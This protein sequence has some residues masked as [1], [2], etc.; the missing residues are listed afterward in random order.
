MAKDPNIPAWTGRVG[1]V[2]GVCVTFGFQNR[3]RVPACAIS[4]FAPSHRRGIFPSQPPRLSPHELLY[5]PCSF[6]PVPIHHFSL[7]RRPSFFHWIFFSPFSQLPERIPYGPAT[8]AWFYIQ[9]VGKIVWATGPVPH[10]CILLICYPHRIF[11]PRTSEWMRPISGTGCAI[12]IPSRT[13]NS[14][15][16]AI[17]MS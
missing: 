17:I 1:R 2:G 7:H 10:Y 15:A 11:S 16:S 3:C 14:V 12:D 4:T 9:I 8:P 5:I 6:S 13:S